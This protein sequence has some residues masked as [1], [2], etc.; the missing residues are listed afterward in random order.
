MSRLITDLESGRETTIK[1]WKLRELSNALE[2]CKS[3]GWCKNTGNDADDYKS[4]RP[5]MI[6][7][8]KS[9]NMIKILDGFMKDKHLLAFLLVH[10][11]FDIGVDKDGEFIE[12]Y[13]ASRIW[14][15]DDQIMKV[16]NRRVPE[17]VC[18]A[19]KKFS[20]FQPEVIPFEVYPYR[21]EFG[22]QKYYDDEKIYHHDPIR[23]ID[24]DIDIS[25]KP[26]ESKKFLDQ[27]DDMVL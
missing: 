24:L 13:M 12:Q 20:P 21:V 5:V 7:A 1:K 10:S 9:K 2:Y 11:V 3:V 22:C 6:E 23:I 17:E 26:F 8:N 14:I 4:L 15:S 25:Q 18:E 16:F 27:F 19:L